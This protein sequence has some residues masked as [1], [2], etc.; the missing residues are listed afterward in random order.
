MAVIG[1]VIGG[2][3]VG[4]VMYDNHSDYSD[5]GNYGNYSNYS[6]AAERRRR[7]IEEKKREIDSQKH[8]IN[9]YKANSVNDYLKSDSLKQQSGVDVNVSQ[10]KSD[11]DAK[12]ED[13]IRT[14]IDRSCADSVNEI[15]DLNQAIKKIDEILWRNK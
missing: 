9:T 6:D 1:A 15:N 3:V 14:D 13:E 12:I 8:E 2:A 5:Y 11:G 10:V 7:R 4:A